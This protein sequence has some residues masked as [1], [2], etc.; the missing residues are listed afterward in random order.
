M[1]FG[2]YAGISRMWSHVL[3][4]KTSVK[5]LNYKW[6]EFQ[7][8][9]KLSL[10]GHSVDI[11]DYRFFNIPTFVI[12]H[13]SETGAVDVKDINEGF[14]FLINGKTYAAAFLAVGTNEKQQFD[15]LR[16]QTPEQAW[17]HD[18]EHFARNGGFSSHFEESRTKAHHIAD[19]REKIREKELGAEEHAQVELAFFHLF[20]EDQKEHYDIFETLQ[21]MQK[22]CRE[23]VNKRPVPTE[24]FKSLEAFE[25]YVALL[26]H[27]GLPLPSGDIVKQYQKHQEHLLKGLEILE[28]FA[29][30]YDEAMEQALI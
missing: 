4:G 27:L 15:Y 7:Y 11:N 9:R 28:P 5:F 22:G 3:S 12:P 26:P 23:R 21:H 10:K 6:D 18:F 25:S 13:V 19:L 1:S 29:K 24:G 20:H 14:G 8:A 17:Y 2:Y 16:D 30:E